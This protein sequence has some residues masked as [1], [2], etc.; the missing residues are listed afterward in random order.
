M[1]ESR[2]MTTPEVVAK[3]L[4][5]E[6]ADFLKE[7][8]AMVAHELMEAEISEQI[9]AGHGKVSSE[10]ATHRNGYRPRLW[11]TRVGEIELAVPRKRE[12]D[13]YFP[14][15][16]VPR[17]PCEQAIAPTGL[18][19]MGYSSP[20]GG[21]WHRTSGVPSAGCGDP[22][23]AGLLADPSFELA[24]DLLARAPE[25][26]EHVVDVGSRLH[27]QPGLVFPLGEQRDLQRAPDRHFPVVTRQLPQR[28]GHL[29]VRESLAFERVPAVSCS[30]LARGARLLVVHDAFEMMW[31]LAGS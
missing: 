7:A 29:D 19:P 10:R 4:I 9:D 25:G 3:T 23:G 12:G 15:F 6:H 28:L 8:V 2:S 24:N 26:G 14:S 30:T 16:L 5:A 20:R 18:T 13:S 31:W 21:R 22:I 11:E 17:R 27:V 1:A